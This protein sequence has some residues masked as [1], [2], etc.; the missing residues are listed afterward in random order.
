MQVWPEVATQARAPAEGS[1]TQT[2]A[3]SQS[4]ASQAYAMPQQVTTT[5]QAS[6]GVLP[7]TPQLL[8]QLAEQLT[9][10][11]PALTRPG[12][13]AQDE[14]SVITS[15][16]AELASARQAM[17]LM[18][19]LLDTMPQS[20]ESAERP[21]EAALSV[22]GVQ[23]LLS[24]LLHGQQASSIP[25]DQSEV[26]AAQAAELAS[27][28]QAMQLLAQLLEQEAA[29]GSMSETAVQA[30]AHQDAATAEAMP[31]PSGLQQALNGILHELSTLS[32]APHAHQVRSCII[33]ADLTISNMLGV[34]NLVL[35]ALDDSSRACNLTVLVVLHQSRHGS[36]QDRSPVCFHG[37]HCNG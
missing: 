24:Q 32:A 2:V 6:E 34:L 17:Q 1:A 27:A 23:E 4:K 9:A 21:E 3:R 37:V 8:Q 11:A 18:A 25:Q 19:Q 20:S 28:R 29:G 15:Q 10:T 33:Q 7:G 13:P 35:L 30:P 5:I 16:A 12:S 22:Q 31:S 36:A 14:S 26:I